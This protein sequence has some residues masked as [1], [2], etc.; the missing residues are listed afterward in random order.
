MATV[1]GERTAGERTAGEAWV[2]PD[3]EFVLLVRDALRQVHDPVAL[4]VHPLA[5]GWGLPMDGRAAGAG[6][7]PGAALCQLLLEAVAALRPPA[8]SPP[9]QPAWR[10]HRLLHLRYVEALE[11]PAVQARLA[12]GRSQYFRDHRA[13]LHAVVALVAER[14]GLERVA[15]GIR[16]AAPAFGPLGPLGHAELAAPAGHA[17]TL[18]A[19]LTRLVGHAYQGSI[20]CASRRQ[21]VAAHPK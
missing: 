21:V 7:D 13:A 9:H 16:P 6:R 2:P 11:V 17:A 20:S 5:G 4:R 14:A 12:L 15:G 19:P 18:P 3:Q 8:G 10:H 1:A